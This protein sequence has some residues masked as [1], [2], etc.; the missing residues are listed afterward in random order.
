M[1][2]DRFVL[3][4][5]FQYFLISIAYAY[6]GFYFKSLYWVGAILISIAVLK[7]K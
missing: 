7:M 3:L 2:G 6:Q 1:I 4:L 5:I